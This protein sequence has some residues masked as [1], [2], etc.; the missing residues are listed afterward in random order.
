[1]TIAT[2][3]TILSYRVPSDDPKWSRFDPLWAALLALPGLCGFS[4]LAGALLFHSELAW[5]IG[6]RV[7]LLIWASALVTAIVSFRYFTGRRKSVMTRICLLLN[8]AGIVFTILP[9]GWVI[10]LMALM[11]ARMV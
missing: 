9:S 6:P 1:M 8:W 2:S 5:R 10:L 7:G 4:L 3:S 11:A